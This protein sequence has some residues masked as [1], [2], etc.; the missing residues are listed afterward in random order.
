MKLDIDA[1]LQGMTQE[2]DYSQNTVAA[3]RN[4]LTQLV[5]FINAE[6]AKGLTQSYDEIHGCFGE[7]EGEPD[8]TFTFFSGRQ[9]FT[10]LLIFC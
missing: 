1:F 5:A 8:S 2:K 10:Q 7:D 9:A 4:D 3:Y 6:Q